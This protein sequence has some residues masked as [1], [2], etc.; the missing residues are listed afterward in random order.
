MKRIAGCMVFIA[1]AVLPTI[2]SAQDDGQ[3]SGM[4]AT[5]VVAEGGAAADSSTTSGWFGG[6]AL[7]QPMNRFGIAVSG[8]WIDAGPGSTGFAGDISAEFG[9]APKSVRNMPYVRVGFGAY[10]ADFDV[11][12]AAHVAKLPTFYQRRLG[13]LDTVTQHRTFTD[14]AFV[15]AAGIDVPL[16]RSVSVRP[17]VRGMWVVRDGHAYQMVLVGLQLAYH[18]EEHPVTPSRSA[19]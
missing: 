16:S 6:T 8:R 12:D 5:A 18:I 17:D 11:T 15:A 3:R 1:T 14:P 2:A 10:R 19:R 9:L 7:W 4:H 13:A